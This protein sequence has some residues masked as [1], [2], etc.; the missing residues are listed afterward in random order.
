VNA[1][2]FVRHRCDFA[3]MFRSCRSRV[4]GSLGD[5]S[6]SAHDAK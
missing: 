1:I 5:N 4:S 2:D 6:S 3:D